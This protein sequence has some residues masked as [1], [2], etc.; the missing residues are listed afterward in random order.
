M[1]ST[2][3]ADQTN[4]AVQIEA[5]LERAKTE[6]ASDILLSAGMPPLLFINGQIRKLGTVTLSSQ[7]TRALVYGMLEKNEIA[8]FESE[9]E[10][11]FSITYQEQFRFRCNAFWQKGTVGAALRLIPQSVPSLETLGLPPV[12]AELCNLNHGLILITGPTGHG[13]STTMASMIDYIN[14]TRSCHII[15]V[16]DP[17]EFLHTNAKSVIEQREV[18]TDTLSFASALRHV[19]R[20]APHVIQVGEMRDLD[21]ISTALTAAETGHLVISTLHTNDAVQTMDRIIDVFPPHQQNQIRQQLSGSLQAVISQRLIPKADKSGRV[22]ACEILRIN[23]AVANLI[24]ENRTEQIQAV[25]ETQSKRGMIAM[26]T[27]IKQLFLSGA[28]TED[29]ARKAMRHPQ[30]LFG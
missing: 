27:T 22:L 18:G 19:L 14:H 1:S 8:H 28:I 16:E 20:Q 10:L 13:K 29:E 4:Q 9:R 23:T 25:I 12:T 15:T 6:S 26:D 3:P 11:D 2:P 21:T 17:V 5:I 7:E 30:V 24:R